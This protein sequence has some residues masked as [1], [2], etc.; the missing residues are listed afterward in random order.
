MKSFLSIESFS[1]DV[2]YHRYLEDGVRKEEFVTFQPFCGVESA[3]NSNSIIKSLFN[4]PLELRK[5]DTITEY[6]DWKRENEN[7]IPIHGDVRMEYMFASSQYQGEIPIQWE[8]MRIDNFDI[9]VHTGGDEDGNILDKNGKFVLDSDGKKVPA[10][11]FPESKDAF[12]PVSA[13]AIQDIITKTYTVFGWKDYNNQ[14]DDVTYYRCDDEVDLLKQYVAFMSERKPD[15][16]TGW[17][18]VPFDIPYIIHRI[19]K[20]LG[21]PWISKLSQIDK[22]RKR[23]YTDGFDN[24]I[25][26]YDIGGS[27]IYD[28]MELYGK[29]QLEP[30]DGKSLEIIA[31]AELGKGKLDYKSGDNRT[32]PELF[33]KDF[34][35][36]INYN[37]KDTSLVG[38]IDDK[39]QYIQ[40]AVNMTYMAKCMFTDVF[41]TVGI[42][43]AYLYNVL[44]E[45]KIL[46]P[47]KKTNQKS[48]FPGGWVK[49]PERGMHGWNMVFDIASSYPNS[50]ITYNISPECIIEFDSLPA[51]LQKLA[52]SIRPSHDLTTNT[53]LISDNI[54]DIHWIEENVKPLLKKY[55]VCM[56]GWGEFFRRDKIGFIPE[57]VDHIFKSR[58]AVKDEMKHIS[59]K[60]SIDVDGI[61]MTLNEIQKELDSL[62]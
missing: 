53:W 21:K 55:D 38:E 2:I 24:E 52:E 45:K 27:V 58:K 15:I 1:T 43:D 13:I 4:K 18:I 48:P 41:G 60:M 31:Q 10:G 46:C 23:T 19:S 35:E 33:E 50:I 32:L 3:S 40:L 22:I 37:I 36:Y 28:Y 17:N 57:V 12:F 29:F 9:E 11:G 5:F 8:H 59:E 25:I 30:R 49:E 47:P 20:V 39:R 6:R 61:E 16:L 44:L 54:Y 26:T 42:W 51:E 14:R 62:K 7:F 56:T 34:Q